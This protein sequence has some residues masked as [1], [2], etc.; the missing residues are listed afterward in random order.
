MFGKPV[1]SGITPHTSGAHILEY[2][3]TINQFQTNNHGSLYCVNKRLIL[4]YLKDLLQTL[5]L[6]KGASLC[7]DSNVCSV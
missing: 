7:I 6:M 3:H 1:G 4:V 2:K 5:I